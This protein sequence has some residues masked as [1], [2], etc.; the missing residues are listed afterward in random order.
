MLVAVQGSGYKQ[1]RV[2]DA[3]IHQYICGARWA[4]GGLSSK[5]DILARMSHFWSQTSRAPQGMSAVRAGAEDRF[6]RA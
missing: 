5:G 3:V 1:V 2:P 4:A 6:L